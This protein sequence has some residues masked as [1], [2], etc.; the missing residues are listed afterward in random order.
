MQQ[1]AFS[2]QSFT[3]HRLGL[4]VSAVLLTTLGS[5]SASELIAADGPMGMAILGNQ[6]GVPV[7]DIVAPNTQGLSHNRW[8][9]YNVGTA[10]LVLNNSLAAGQVQLGG[11]AL[12]IGANRQFADVAASTILNEV[13]G[14]RG[15]TIA[16]SQVIFGQAADYVLSN[17]NGIEL[18]G[19]RM[20]LDSAH[21]ATY[22]V[23]TPAFSDGV[24][25]QYDTRSQSPAEHRLV[26]G[27]NGLDVGTGSVRLIA[28]TVQK[29]GA[30]TAG[31]DL[32]LLLGNHLVDSRALSTE[33]VARSSAA[34]DAS[35]LGAM[36][37][38]RIKI[39]STD[40]GVGLNMGITRLR[41]DKGI[42]ISSAGALSIGSSVVNQGQYGQ[43]A[44]DAGE[45][46]L[47][48]SAGGDMSLT[49]VAIDAQNIDARSRGLLRLDALSNQT[50]T[51]RQA[52]ADEHWF[53]LAAGESDAQ[54]TERS[55]THI[56]NRL[57]ATRNVRLDGRS[58]IEMAA[59]RID[60]PENVGLYTVRGGVQLGA[61]MDQSWRTV[62]VPSLDGSDDSASTYTETAQATHIEGGTVSLP[63]ATLLGATIN[64]T[65]SIDIGGAGATHIG[66]LDFKRTLTQGTDAR[67]VSLT[68]TLAHEALQERRYQQ[69]SQLQAPNASL[70]LQ[71]TE[72][73]IVG[74]QLSAKDVRLQ[75]D[76][77]VAIEGGSEDARIEGARPAAQ[78]FQR[79]FDRS[80]QSNV[81]SFVQ[82]TDTLAIR[83][84]RSTFREGSV[85]VSGSHLLGDKAVIV[86]AEDNV[87]IS[88][89]DEKQSFNLSGPQWG[90]VP[91][92]LPQTGAW[93]RKGFRESQARSTLGGAGSLHV[94]AGGMLDVAGSYLDTGGDIKLAAADIQL[95]GSLAPT[96]P[97]NETIWLD[98]DLP[99]YYFAPVAGGTDARVTD[100]INNG[101]AMKAGGSIDITAKRLATHAASV[102]AADQLTLSSGLAL[103]K[104]TPVEDADAIRSNYHGYVAP[105]PS[106]W[107]SL[108]GLPL[109]AL[110]VAVPSSNGTTR[111]STFVAGEVSADTA[112]RI[113]ALN[114]PLTLR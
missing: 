79:S 91:G 42:E 7:V 34:V 28:P 32:T 10:G 97:R 104:D 72:I 68:D 103:F 48:L 92:E 24:I 73:R 114:I 81:A 85:S 19:A 78:Q 52:S 80:A 11:V 40:Q 1:A 62:R 99:G 5:A 89:A 59:T 70:S 83:A 93:S 94:S 74:S 8:Q 47:V 2:T 82:A 88:S 33:A 108:A 60:G 67:R 65:H 66:S 16:G 86:D 107:Q 63:T 102:N 20:T 96:G 36:H 4:A 31:D 37:A 69:P 58:G 56:G 84:R 98:N 111:E 41:G 43:A 64:A 54:I 51:Q 38:R 14:T 49:S 95:T 12:D 57:T 27:Q 77:T 113:Q 44:I 101:F 100:R 112:R 75:F 30:I 53:T 9:D 3:R 18:N 39:V 46:D 26:V 21:T 13:V 109:A 76:G 45:Q 87:W 71:G 15:S 55:L 50:E 61:K 22:V 110:D 106:N 17:P 6:A 25:S 35:L 90:P 23:G 29:T 105:R